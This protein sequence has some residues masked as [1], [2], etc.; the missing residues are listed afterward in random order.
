MLRRSAS[1]KRNGKHVARRAFKVAVYV[2][3]GMIAAGLLEKAE[4]KLGTRKRY[5]LGKLYKFLPHN[6]T[7]EMGLE[8]GDLSDQARSILLSLTISSVQTAK[9]ME[10]LLK[11]P[12]A[13]K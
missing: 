10:E 3:S 12:A 6:V 4:K 7:T 11:S 13:P 9:F 1:S 2:L 5:L 8:L